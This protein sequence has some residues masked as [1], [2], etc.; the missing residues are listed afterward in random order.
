MAI[1]HFGHRLPLIRQ[2]EAAECGLACLAMISSFYGHRIDLNTLRQRHPVSLKGAT[3]RLLI[4]VAHNLQLASRAL[5]LEPPALKKLRLPA[6]LHWDLN[7]FVTLKA[8][9]KKGIIIYDPASGERRL[10]LAETSKHFTGVALELFPAEGF[11]RRN[12]RAR[13]PFSIF[14]GHL[15]G[16]GHALVQVFVL[17]ILLQMLVLAGPFYLQLTVDEVIARGDIDFLL[18]LALGFA[19]MT[20]VRNTASAVRSS[21]SL[22][23]QNVLH[24]HLGARI[25]R[26]LIRL[27]LTFYENRHIG[28]ILSR[29]SSLQP[30]RTALAEGMI[31]ALLDGLMATL[32]LT[33]LLIYSVD[34]ALIV[35]G[36]F[37]LYAT[38]RLALYRVL[39]DRTEASI[40][41]D[42]VQN[43]V[44]IESVR[45]I[46]SLKLCNRESERESQWLNRFAEV[47]SA[48]VRLG[49]ARIAFS[50]INDL[51]FGIELI[52]II[53]LAAKLTLSNHLT[54]GMIF[55]F[56][57]YRQQFVEKSV[58]LV[59]KVLDFR[60]LGLHLERL[61]DIALTPL[62][63]GHDRLLGYMRPI[64]GA[65]KLRGVFFR[66]SETEPFVLEDVN[67]SIKAGEFVTIM[68]PSGGGKTTLMKIML[69]LFEPTSGEVYVDGISLRTLGA[70]AFREQVGAVMQDD[71]LL[72]G[73]VAE[74][75]CF[76]DPDFDR[77]AMI[78]SAQLACVHDEIMD[79][80]MTYNSLVGDMGSSLSGGQK[81]RVLLARA[82]YRHPK[83]LF[84][85]E[86]TAH[87]DID[88]ERRINAS[89]RELCMTRISVAH[90]PDIIGGT[91][92]IIWVE[93]GAVCEKGQGFPA[94][95]DGSIAA[96]L[97]SH[98]T[99][100]VGACTD[101]EIKCAITDTGEGRGATDPA[102]L[103][104]ATEKPMQMIDGTVAPEGVDEKKE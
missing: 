62:D 33:M 54:V 98:P 95:W 104:A 29:F 82:L 91:E 59:E 44:L 84:L 58:Q 18:V 57:S 31:S 49:R 21:I 67:L 17:S 19:L 3:I 34:L 99:K 73:S 38:L 40:Q 71:Q 5:R 48:N 15:S 61:S 89:L 64:R 102:L 90:R 53:Y 6:I 103:T 35:I 86:G 22:I 9:S 32:T 88:N 4:Q 60:I 83:I 24:F 97:T 1:L 50:T 79:M 27:P 76:F 77:E 100:G 14:W 13:L 80:P 47:A 87:L 52:V 85:D 28:D 66:Y 78:R 8:V 10:S 11:V 51:I 2:T 72:S 42:A 65:I 70:R 16:S 93:R 25:F 36:A 74:N 81:Q 75:I 39:W 63:A 56:M 45:A 69:G 43:S 26:H 23:L 101:A 7:H 12:E 37:V 96:N 68:G 92:R 46:Q 30:I 55:A 20:L 94:P 41:A